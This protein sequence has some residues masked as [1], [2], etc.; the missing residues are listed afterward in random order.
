MCLTN[1]CN[2]SFFQDEMK[3]LNGHCTGASI[4]ISNNIM[5]LTDFAMVLVT[6][7]PQVRKICSAIRLESRKRENATGSR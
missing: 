5:S 1:N 7:V 4:Q 3:D 2:R 6:F